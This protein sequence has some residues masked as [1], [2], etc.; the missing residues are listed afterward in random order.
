M[1][2]FIDN[3]GQNCLLSGYWK[4]YREPEKALERFRLYDR[5]REELAMAAISGP[6][7]PL[8]GRN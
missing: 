6:L 2:G 4:V 5:A 1:I 8:A 3:K 7:P